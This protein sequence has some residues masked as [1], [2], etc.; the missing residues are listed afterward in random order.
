MM[1]DA[2]TG[3]CGERRDRGIRRLPR[4]LGALAAAMM[5]AVSA[6]A[7]AAMI[8]AQT[9]SLHT[10][11]AAGLIDLSDAGTLR[12]YSAC[13]ASGGAATSGR[14]ALDRPLCGAALAPPAREFRLD[15][16]DAFLSLGLAGDT[17]GPQAIGEVR[18]M[19]GFRHLMDGGALAGWKLGADVQL[20]RTAFGTLDTPLDEQMHVSLGRE[21]AGWKLGFNAGATRLDAAAPSLATQTMTFA[22][23]IARGFSGAAAG[24]SH[25]LSLRLEEDSTATGAW[26]WD[27][28]TTLA[29]LGY[30]YKRG[31]GSIGA[32]VSLSRADSA[33]VDAQSSARSEIKFRHPF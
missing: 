17:T 20:G 32:E 3:D 1:Q 29:S 19:L 18:S 21:V 7:E 25:R 2:R 31:I 9:A 8:E 14:P 12:P 15:R 23:G 4:V 27:Q 28:R 6:P 30:D 16:A 11:E 26:G 24:E 22:A 5:A 33:G 10:A 13:T